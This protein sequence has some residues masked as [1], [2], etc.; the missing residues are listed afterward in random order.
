MRLIIVRHGETEENIKGI[1][2]GHMPGVLTKDGISQA[3]KVALRLRDAKIGCIY[4]SDLA[5]A[6]DT[7]KEIHK[8][9]KDTP[10]IY[11][12]KLREMDLGSFSGKLWD[13]C[14]WDNRPDDMET[15][16]SLQKRVK[17]FLDTLYDEHSDDVVCVVSHSGTNKNL[18]RIIFGE[19]NKELPHPGN[20]AVTI[21]DFDEDKNHKIK[22]L[23]CIEH[24]DAQD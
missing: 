17:E 4:S 9:H 2:Q 22:V 11:T 14:D 6:A 19:P 8:Y 18:L 16:E 3:K 23:N 15:R 10:L 20:T 12:E 7:A 5:R 13:E 24:L 21:I 1:I